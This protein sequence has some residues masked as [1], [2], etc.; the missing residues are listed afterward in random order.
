MLLQPLADAGDGAL[1]CIRRRVRSVED[2]H[3]VEQDDG[4]PAALALADLGP[5]LGEE[6]FDVLPLDV[7]ARRMREDNFNRALMLPLHPRK[8][9]TNWYQPGRR[10]NL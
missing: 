4:N 5:E 1:V 9:I 7:C 8:G 6:R 10:A 2:T 3:F